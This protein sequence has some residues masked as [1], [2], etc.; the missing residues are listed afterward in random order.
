[1]EGFLKITAGEGMT[2]ECRLKHVGKFDKM[3]LL[4][5]FMKALEMDQDA[6]IEAMLFNDIAEG[7]M[8]AISGKLG[9]DDDKEDENPEIMQAQFDLDAIEK[10]YGKKGQQEDS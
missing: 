10:L 5:S 4:H 7:V 2:V 9:G 1:M 8:K 6:V 3:M